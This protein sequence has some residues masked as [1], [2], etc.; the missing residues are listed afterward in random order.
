MKPIF[1]VLLLILLATPATA[2]ELTVVS[3]NVESDSKYNKKSNTKDT[4][5]DSVAK[6]LKRIPK[7]H[8]WGLSEVQ[9]KDFETYRK[10]I[11]KNFKLIEGET[12]GAD[13]LAIVFDPD[14]LEQIGDMDELSE[15]GGSRHPLIEKFKVKRTEQEF[16]F[17]VNHL[18]RGA[19][20]VRKAQAAWLN[21][22]AREEAKKKNPSAIILVGD[23]NFDV[24]PY[25]KQ[26]N[27]AYELFMQNGM[28]R[29]VEPSCIA[30]RSCPTTGTGCN[31]EYNS[32]L[33]FVFLAGSA[34]S[35]KAKS[36]I[37]F[38]DEADYCEKEESG[39]S[40][41]RPIRAVLTIPSN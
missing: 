34:R 22:W 1:G 27:P 3:Y 19:N 10:A 24:N 39:G 28:F 37:L 6:D 21:I 7:S 17:V 38:K 12:G 26:G 20:S 25:T 9:K 36:E 2:F 8:I 30:D 5:P 14:V 16:L 23:Y 31:S 11:G 35:W 15:A 41:H 40:D 18:Q 32:I 33:D 29:W 13:R 4:E